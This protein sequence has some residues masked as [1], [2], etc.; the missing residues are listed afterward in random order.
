MSYERRKIRIGKVVSD[1]MQKTVVVMVEWRSQHPL[2]RK[3]IRRHSR[4]M[5]HDPEGKCRLGDTVR[6]IE[7]RPISKAKRWRVTDI[8]AHE[9]MA[10]EIRPEEIAVP[11]EIQAPKVAPVQ[12]VAAAPAAVEAEATAPA[13]VP[14][15][16]SGEEKPTPKRSRA[17]AEA[18]GQEAAGAED[19]KPKVPRKT[20]AKAE[21]PSSGDGQGDK[22]E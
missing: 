4:F 20:R 17:K 6:I 5:A 16:A 15:A 21:K 12:A 19:V 8:L 3:S 22:T 10:T 1:K 9:E 18:T 13:E 11:E 2:Y 7:T 14:V